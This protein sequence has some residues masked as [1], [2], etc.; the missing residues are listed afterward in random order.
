MRTYRH[1]VEEGDKPYFFGWKDNNLTPPDRVGAA[2]L[3][4][5]RRCF[6]QR[7]RDICE[8]ADQSSR[9][10]ADPDRAGDYFQ[11]RRYNQTDRRLKQSP[12]LAG[13]CFLTSED[14]YDPDS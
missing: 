7:I 4:K 10:T 1:H 13:F 6:G 8:R 12:A 2:N 3:D 14:G 9:W 5:T 11:P